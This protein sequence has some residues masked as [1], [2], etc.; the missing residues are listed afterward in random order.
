MAS[1]YKVIYRQ[2]PGQVDSQ[3]RKQHKDD[4]RRQYD[5]PT[6]QEHEGLSATIRSWENKITNSPSIS[7]MN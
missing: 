6:S 7:G 3:G 1:F 5:T 2:Q 4:R